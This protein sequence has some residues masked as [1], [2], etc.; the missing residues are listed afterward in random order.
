VH[1]AFRST[2]SLSCADV[3][4]AESEQDSGSLPPLQL[5]VRVEFEFVA[6]TDEQ[7][8]SL[9]L[10]VVAQL[11]GEVPA[12]RSA[13]TTIHADKSFARMNI[14]KFLRVEFSL[15]RVRAIVRPHTALHLA[16]APYGHD[17]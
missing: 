4:L 13:P 2:N 12:R 11:G 3:V 1:D 17:A 16:S 5:M 14:P 15:R 7:D 9:M 8:A 10:R 6:V